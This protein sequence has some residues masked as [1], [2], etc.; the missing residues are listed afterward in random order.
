MLWS[1]AAVSATLAVACTDSTSPGEES[2]EWR[3]QIAAGDRIEI[4]G[5]NGGIL[6]QGTTANEVVVSAVKTSQQSDV[7]EVRIDVVSHANGV[8]IC[9]VYPDVPGQPPNECLPGDQGSMSVE[10]ND[11]NVA[12]DVSVPMDVVFVGRTVNGD[13]IADGLGANGFV[14]TVNGDAAV[15]TSGLGEATTVNGSVDAS[16]GLPDWDRDLGFLAVNGNVTVTI[17]AATNA[18]V[19]LTTVNGSITS[20]FPLTEVSPVNYQGTIG[21]GGRVLTATTVNGGV[22]L[23]ALVPFS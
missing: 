10:G 8:T 16:I 13:V 5:V 12:F 19:R 7:S 18:E 11:V 6:A 23:R 22:V 15:T 1:A 17:P 4:K 3:G 9:A 21:T 20:D 14:M 2:F